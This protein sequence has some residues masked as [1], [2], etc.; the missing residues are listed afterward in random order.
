MNSAWTPV[1]AAVVAVV[2]TLAATIFTQMWNARREDRRRADERAEKGLANDRDDRIRLQ[3]QRRA[4]YF[5]YLKALHD[6][7]EEIRGI[8][9]ES[10]PL[11][12]GA[13]KAAENV[14][15]NSGLLA[16][17]EEI[18]LVATLDLAV[19]AQKSFR[20]VVAFRDLVLRGGDL[21]GPERMANWDAHREALSDLR[22]AM[23]N[24]LGIP[25]L[26][27]SDPRRLFDANPSVE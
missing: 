3:D 1:L 9:L 13:K 26:G 14:I 4:A 10:Q 2:G 7:S 23:R 18:F 27:V 5:N 24:N 25:D 20:S 6:A 11:D 12:A 19:A 17:R 22:V 8:A 16:A 15:R 21:E